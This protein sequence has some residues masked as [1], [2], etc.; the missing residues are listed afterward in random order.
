MMTLRM[1]N[2]VIKKAEAG[3]VCPQAFR[4][5]MAVAGGRNTMTQ[6]SWALSCSR[7]SEEKVRRHTHRQSALS[8]EEST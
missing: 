7:S 6:I 2:S 4:D 8:T 1:P 5:L 3:N